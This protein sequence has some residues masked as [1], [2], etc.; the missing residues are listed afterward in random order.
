M[1]ENACDVNRVQLLYTDEKTENTVVLYGVMIL[2]SLVLMDLIGNRID[3]L[4]HCCNSSGYIV[5]ISTS[6]FIRYSYW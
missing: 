3:N 6:G 1:A 4:Q 5:L 2:L